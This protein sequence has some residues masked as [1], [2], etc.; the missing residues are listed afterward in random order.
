MD[1]TIASD[2]MFIFLSFIPIILYIAII[3][4]AL[5]FVIKVIRFMNEKT[6][7]DRERNE[8]LTKIINLLSQNKED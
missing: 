3:V 5:Y 7:H 1:R 6:K 4:F 2:G 8:K